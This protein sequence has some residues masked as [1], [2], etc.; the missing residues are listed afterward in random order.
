MWYLRKFSIVGI[1]V[2]AAIVIAAS[3]TATAQNIRGAATGPTTAKGYSHPE[4]SLHL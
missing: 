1:A 3:G 2:L 4:Q